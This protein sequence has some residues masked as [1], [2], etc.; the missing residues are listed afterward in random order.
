MKTA[1]DWKIPPVN[2]SLATQEVH[3]WRVDLNLPPKQLQEVAKTLSPDEQ[4][5]ADRFRFEQHRQRFIA[6]RGILRLLLGQYLQI[7]PE[8]LKFDYQERG[9][10][11]LANSQLQFNLAHS[12]DLALY[13]IT[14]DRAVGIDLEKIRAIDD[15]ESLS[16]RFFSKNEHALLCALPA[17][18]RLNVFFRYWTCKEAYLKAT[19]AGLANLKGLEISLLPNRSACLTMQDWQLQELTPAAEFAGAIVV[20]GQNSRFHYW[21]LPSDFAPVAI[22]LF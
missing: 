15:L 22:T 8:T 9:K 17:S 12:Q 21:R 1:D 20:S 13:A 10:P 2:L 14:R 11:F 16:H 3:I 5:R 7:A 18:E 19:G 6:G 4:H